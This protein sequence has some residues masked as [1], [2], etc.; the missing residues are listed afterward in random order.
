V[1]LLLQETEFQE[2]F[3]QQVLRLFTEVLLGGADLKEAF[4]ELVTMIKKS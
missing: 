3:L 4:K 1:Q 2:R